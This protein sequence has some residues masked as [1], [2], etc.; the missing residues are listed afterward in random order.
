V[1]ANL[2]G[3]LFRLIKSPTGDIFKVSPVGYQPKSLEEHM[4]KVKGYYNVH[5][6]AFLGP[7]TAS[8]EGSKVAHTPRYVE[9]VCFGEYDTETHAFVPST[10]PMTIPKG[11]VFEQDEYIDANGKLVSVNRGIVE[12]VGMDLVSKKLIGFSTG[13]LSGSNVVTKDETGRVYEDAPA[14]VRKQAPEPLLKGQFKQSDLPT[15]DLDRL[16][17]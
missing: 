5:N 7:M 13:R 4:A 9:G 1:F 17:K 3:Q 2:L 8:A 10:N 6:G 12:D 11:S 16:F 15:I 14:P